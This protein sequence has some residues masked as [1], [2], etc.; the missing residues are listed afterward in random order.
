M[1]GLIQREDVR[2]GLSGDGN[3]FLLI[4]FAHNEFGIIRGIEQPV[5]FKIVGE[6]PKEWAKAFFATETTE[7]SEKKTQKLCVLRG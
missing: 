4:E 7:F 3:E 2:R 6:C 5:L 1:G